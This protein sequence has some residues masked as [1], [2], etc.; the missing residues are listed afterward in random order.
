MTYR[1]RMMMRREKQAARLRAYRQQRYNN[2]LALIMDS[3][4][5][6][7]LEIH[8]IAGDLDTS[9]PDAAAKL[10]ALITGR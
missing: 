8:E 5:Q 4:E 10:R 3:L 9:N 2:K 6:M 1:E 7:M